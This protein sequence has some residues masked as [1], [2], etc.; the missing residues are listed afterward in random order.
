[1][2]PGQIS[3]HFA[4]PR[5]ALGCQCQP[6][7]AV[8]TDPSLVQ[9][10]DEGKSAN[11]GSA[12]LDPQ[13]KGLKLSKGTAKYE[14]CGSNI[15]PFVIVAGAASHSIRHVYYVLF[16]AICMC[17]CCHLQLHLLLFEFCSTVSVAICIYTNQAKLHPE[18]ASLEV[19]AL[20]RDVRDGED[21]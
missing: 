15:M 10:D 9:T 13:F 4:Q 6:L 18:A 7:R 19:C 17:V 3:S 5:A 1:M 21:W 12:H 16:D 8:S 14:K 2:A 20:V 11:S